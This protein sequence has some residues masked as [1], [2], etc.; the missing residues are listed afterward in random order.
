MST[1]LSSVDLNLLV[2]LDAL[3]AERSVTRAGQRLSLSQPAMSAA[4]ARLRRLFGDPLLVRDGRTLRPTPLAESLAEPVRGILTR[5]E[6]TL[7]HRL[8]FDPASDARTFSVIASDYVTVVLLRPLFERLA[9]RAPQVRVAVT[10]LGPEFQEQI[11][12]DEADLLIVPREVA[13]KAGD[14]PSETLF[15]DRFVC[16]VWRDHP[17]VG[18]TMTVEQLGALPYLTYGAPALASF[19]DIQLDALGVTRQVEVTTQSFAIAPFLLRGTRLF[20]MVQERLAN[21]VAEAANIRLLEPPLD[22]SPITEAMFWHP[23]H[24]S[25]PAHRWLR[26]QIAELAATLEAGH[27]SPITST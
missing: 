26:T 2:A 17:A 8:R 4:L 14:L 5:V 15:V 3:L 19:V 12:R 21:E 23:R 13:D 6:D 18:A 27:E 20:A 25:D 24:S 1:N 7:A 16:A 22:L 10:P 11:R 9:V